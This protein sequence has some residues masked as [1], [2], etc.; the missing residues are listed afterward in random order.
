[1]SF[2]KKCFMLFLAGVT[3][4]GIMWRNPL[5]A[6]FFLVCCG[7]G[8]LYIKRRKKKKLGNKAKNNT[9]KPKK[10]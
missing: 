6:F 4:S 3:G 1:M 8:H 7:L 2:I 5:L 10:P 9:K